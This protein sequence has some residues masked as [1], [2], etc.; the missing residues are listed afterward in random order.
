MEFH[1]KNGRFCKELSSAID[2]AI[3]FFAGISYSM[4]LLTYISPLFNLLATKIPQ[5][6]IN[7]H[8]VFFLIYF[9]RMRRGNRR[10]E[11][12]HMRFFWLGAALFYVWGIW[13][14]AHVKKAGLLQ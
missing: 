6:W 10:G 5:V 12:I 4:L 3:N 8:L 14:I 13:F 9:N 7:F 11:R 1:G 2:K